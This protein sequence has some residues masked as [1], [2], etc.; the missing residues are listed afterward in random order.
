MTA[1]SRMLVRWTRRLGWLLL[2]GAALALLPPRALAWE[3]F[4]SANGD[5]LRGNDELKKGQLDKALAAY[6]DAAKR[7]PQEPGV[8]LDRGIAL[9]KAGKLNEAR[10]ALQ[11][12]TQGSP[13]PEV[14]AK[15]NYNLGLAF[16]QEAEAA[17]KSEDLEAGQKL[18]R[19]AADAFKNSL[20]AGPKNRDAAWNL[21]LAKRRQ[22]ELE[23]KQQEKKDQEKKEQDEKKDQE[24]KDQQDQDQKQD[25][26]QKSDDG[27]PKQ[28]DQ[29]KQDPSQQP[30]AGAPQGAEDAGQ[31]DPQ[32]G[33]DAGAPKPKQDEPPKQDEQP[34]EGQPQQKLPE[35]MQKAL[36]ALEDSNENLQ[37]HQAAM[38]ARQQ[39]QRVVK[40]W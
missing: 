26:A 36:D 1:G 23:K 24:K 40:D 3:P 39:P 13:S 32:G 28:N 21:E 27:E 10:D 17:A 16:L 35:H 38:R 9:L 19:E 12:A 29:D 37:K 6:S 14:R 18:L 25:D 4:R 7:L 31:P 15:A 8:H 34:G 11:I 20:R 30:D 2:A 5:V 33:Q 22:V